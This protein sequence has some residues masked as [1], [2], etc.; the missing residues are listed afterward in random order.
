MT[1]ASLA[2]L[3]VVTSRPVGER[4][5]VEIVDRRTLTEVV[6]LTP[7]EAKLL[8]VRLVERGDAAGR[9]PP[10]V[11]EETANPNARPHNS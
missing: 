9:Q 3:E 2:D 4:P 11:A 10:P 8:G 1:A 7:S 5:L 6:S